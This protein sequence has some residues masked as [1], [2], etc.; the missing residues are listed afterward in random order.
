M[1][2]GPQAEHGAH[3]VLEAHLS[4]RRPWLTCL[5]RAG[6]GWLGSLLCASHQ[7]LAPFPGLPPAPWASRRRV[8]A[9]PSLLV[10]ARWVLGRRRGTGPRSLW[11]ASRAVSGGPTRFSYKTFLCGSQTHDPGASPPHGLTLLHASTPRPSE[12]SNPYLAPNRPR[13]LRL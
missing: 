3:C 2:H 13:P 9:L 8:S 10:A 1:P 11:E 7:A 4:S 12:G 5:Q 6:E